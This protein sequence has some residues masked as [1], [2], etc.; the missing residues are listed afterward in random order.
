MAVAASFACTVLTQES[1][2]DL[3]FVGPQA[4]CYTA[5]R[6]LAHADHMLEILA[7]VRPSHERR[8]SALEEIVV[9]HASAVSGCILVLLHWDAERQRLVQKLHALNLPLTVLVI[10]KPGDRTQF[11]P[12]PMADTPERFVVLDVGKVEEQ[13]AL[14]G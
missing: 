9:N 3:L 6:G 12:G 4:Y 7:A 14:L 10:R 5:G 8:F 11:H 2:L 1:L 13:L